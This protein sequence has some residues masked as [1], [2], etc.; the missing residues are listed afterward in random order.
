MRGHEKSFFRLM[1]RSLASEGLVK[2]RLGDEMGPAGSEDG[3][4]NSLEIDEIDLEELE[5]LDE[6]GLAGEPAET[7]KRAKV[8]E[9][10]PEEA[11]NILPHTVKAYIMELVSGEYV[12]VPRPG[13]S[14][15]RLWSGEKVDKV[16]VMATVVSKFLSNDENYSTLTLDDGTETI[17]IKGWREDARKMDSFQVGDIVDVIASVREY[18]G[19]IYL[20]PL[21][22]NRVGDPNFEPLR[23]LEIFKLRKV[24][25]SDLQL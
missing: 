21:A 6:V 12:R 4:Q 11:A 7:G 15:I 2:R 10:S 16:R 5:E 3:E 24:K 23:E 14:F 13:R 17:R 19:E 22:M 20:S 18:D 25:K 9:A 8:V 1:R